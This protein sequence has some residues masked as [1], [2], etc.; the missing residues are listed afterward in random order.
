MADTTETGY[1]KPV[2][3]SRLSETNFELKWPQSV[4]QY[5]RM[6]REDAQV[7]SLIKGVTL[8]PQRTTWRVDPNGAAVERVRLVAEDLRLPVLGDDGSN[9]VSSSGGHVAWQDVEV[10]RWSK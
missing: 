7:K 5:S 10:A 8:P 1:A 6:V 4:R 2:G 9:P 3:V